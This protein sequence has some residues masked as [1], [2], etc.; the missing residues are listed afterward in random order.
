MGLNL[1]NF[2]YVPWSPVDHGP[3]LIV[4]PLLTMAQHPKLLLSNHVHWSYGQKC[5]AFYLSVLFS[6]AWKVTLRVPDDR[7][8]QLAQDHVQ[9]RD[10]PVAVSLRAEA[11]ARR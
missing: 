9:D 8:T 10:F 6:L 5:T 4:V 7:R 11:S 3:P 1:W 2:G